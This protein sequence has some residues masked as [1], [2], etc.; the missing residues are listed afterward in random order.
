MREYLL[1]LFM[2]LTAVTG[3]LRSYLAARLYKLFNGTR[4]KLLTLQ[5]SMMPILGLVVFIILPASTA[6]PKHLSTARLI[7]TY[8]FTGIWL[9]FDAPS[10]CLGCYLGYIADKI[11]VPAKVS[12][13]HRG[14]PGADAPC[15][16]SS[17]ITI[18]VG[19]LLIGSTLAWETF[20]L[21]DTLWNH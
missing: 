16:T 21:V 18:L 11:T 6:D 19:A 9:L 7:D 14:L 1:L 15:Y 17:S 5:I 10:V 12:R 2:I 20:Y 3:S 8:L 4:W 13:V